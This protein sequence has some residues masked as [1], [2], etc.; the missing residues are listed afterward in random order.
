MVDNDIRIL[1]DKFIGLLTS[2]LSASKHTK[3]VSLTQ[4]T[5]INLHHI[6]YSQELCHHSFVVNLDKCA[7]SC[8]TLDDPSSRV[9]VLNKMCSCIFLI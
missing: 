5:L 8:N 3:C 1:L 6:E 4:P 7:G 9:C 2:I